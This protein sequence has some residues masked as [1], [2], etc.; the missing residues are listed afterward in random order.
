MK[1]STD[2]H[3]V[4]AK[5][6]RLHPSYKKPTQLSFEFANDQ[7][8]ETVICTACTR[9]PSLD[10]L[11]KKELRRQFEHDLEEL[12]LFLTTERPANTN[13]GNGGVS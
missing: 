13:R 11:S 1:L 9:L 2:W 12:G 6:D 10:G 7:S 3:D 8:D 4:R 5:L